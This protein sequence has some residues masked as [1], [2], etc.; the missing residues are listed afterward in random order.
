[1]RFMALPLLVAGCVVPWAEPDDF[2]DTDTDDVETDVETDTEDTDDTEP[3]GNDV[4][5]ADS[6]EDAAD[7]GLLQDGDYT[8]TF[9]GS[10]IS[11]LDPDCSAI[12]PA[13]GQ[14]LYRR[15]RVAK[16]TTLTIE[17]QAPDRDVVLTLLDACASDA[18]VRGADSAV[19]G[20]KETLTWKNEGSGPADLILG[21]HLFD[22][23]EAG[24]NFTL[25]V[26]RE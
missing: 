22:E 11:G 6:C 8:G 17:L 3:A 26:S 2:A 10:D 24:G 20:V 19:E 25:S 12:A 16:N 18:C 14:D 7:L 13:K 9:R 5:L 15:V 23:N 1:M 21:L 4:E